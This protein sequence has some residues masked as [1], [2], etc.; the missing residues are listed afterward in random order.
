MPASFSV[1]QA[2][3]VS[4]GSGKGLLGIETPGGLVLGPLSGMHGHW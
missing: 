1:A 2:V 4:G 3:V